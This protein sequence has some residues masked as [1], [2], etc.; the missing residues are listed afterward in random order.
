[1]KA[2]QE[3][4]RQERVRDVR[5]AVGNI[6]PPADDASKSTTLPIREEMLDPFVNPVYEYVDQHVAE[7][8]TT[9]ASLE[10]R[11]DALLRALQT[12]GGQLPVL[13]DFYRRKGEVDEL[14]M[15]QELAERIYQDVATRYEAARLQVAERS[16][17]LQVVDK[18]LP[19]DRPVSPRPK[20]NVAAAL[21]LAPSAL[22][23]IIVLL[24]A[25]RR[26]LATRPA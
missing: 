4:A 13:A 1:V 14:K 18:A 10:K 19:P 25:L 15:Q 20:L 16:A 7:S 23:T 22:V 12:K 3:L 9:L 24:E 5:R 2:E 17:Q 6:S 8:R 21:V 11:R 26:L